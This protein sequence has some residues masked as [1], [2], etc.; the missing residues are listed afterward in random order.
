M[1]RLYSRLKTDFC[2]LLSCLLLISSLPA[3]A[4]AAD[5]DIVHVVSH[6]KTLVQ[7]DP[8]TGSNSYA[9]WTQ[10][11]ATGESYR[12]VTLWITYACPDGLHCGEW[13]Y[14]DQVMLKRSGRANDPSVN[15][16]LARMIS[17][18]GWR[19]EPDWQFTW[20]SDVTDFALLLHDSVEIEF[21]HTGYE[22]NTD[23]GWLITLDFE[24]QLGPPP[25]R[26][27]GM[28]TLWCGTFP[29]GDSTR[30]IE[31]LLHPIEFRAPVGADFARLRIHQT[32]H[33][34]DDLENCAE[35]CARNR[36]VI[37]D[38]S[39]IN[40]RSLWRECGENPLY[41]QAGTWIF[42]RAN[43]C[44]GAVVYPDVYD[45]PIGKIDGHTV[46]VA[47]E[48]YINPNQPSAN[49]RIYSYL[50]YYTAP[51]S[52]NDISVD[53]ITSPGDLDEY[54]RINPSC[55]Q[56]SFVMKNN[57][58]EVIRSVN[59][60]YGIAGH[61]EHS[62]AWTGQLEPLEQTDVMQ[63]VDL[64]MV[65]KPESVFV[66]LEDPNGSD[67]EFPHDNIAYSI[68][69]PVVVYPTTFVL[70]LRTNR[71]AGETSYRVSDGDGNP[72]R[73]RAPGSMAAYTTY[74]DTLSLDAGCYRLAVADTSGDGLEL[75][76]NPDAGRG[77][78]RFLD[79]NGRLL[80]E[81]TSDFGSSIVHH[82]TTSTEYTA[83]DSS[84]CLAHAFPPRNEGT[85]DVDVFLNVSA[86]ATL[87]VEPEDSD[88]TV[89]SME[90]TNFK[91]GFVPVDISGAP[92][93]IY[94]VIVRAHG[95]EVTQR[96][97]VKR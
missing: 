19:F 27:L 46:D 20:H 75:W 14:I 49:W 12:K 88:S 55:D 13:D 90:L 39:L 71:D 24:I 78:V 3:D 9:K 80:R 69:S 70:E 22:S 59:V 73:E 43:W 28:D 62:Y 41:P 57:G 11:P 44:P 61:E 72:V 66:R 96:I 34:M 40:E 47:M 60:F 30:D 81:F 79:L 38:D 6:D 2:N 68:A 48:P 74:S 25:T 91:N 64:P 76:F 33:G 4:H 42:D 94:R 16:E 65:D 82:F 92:D 54:S 50:F 87:R 32:G 7:T 51:T 37:F 93:G 17:P 95:K 29:Y 52:S 8:S 97:R 85:F 21:V 10:F 26:C 67:D 77:Y 45:L 1:V 56:L 63:F 23:R 35:F 53:E 18:Y 5:G 58:S 31:S 86:A 89:F 15:I 84:V 83:V 36:Q